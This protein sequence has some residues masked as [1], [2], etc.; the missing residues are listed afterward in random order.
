MTYIQN[1]K[2]IALERIKKALFHLTFEERVKVLVA[3]LKHIG[4]KGVDLKEDK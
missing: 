1:P 4:A 3:A 2:N